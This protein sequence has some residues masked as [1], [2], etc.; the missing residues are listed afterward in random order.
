MFT[1]FR[2]GLGVWK[3][4][5]NVRYIVIKFVLLVAAGYMAAAYMAPVLY[6]RVKEISLSLNIGSNKVIIGL[7]LFHM[8]TFGIA[9]KEIVDRAYERN[10]DL[11]YQLAIS[12]RAGGICTMLQQINWYAYAMIVLF[13][14]C[15]DIIMPR[16]LLAL[17]YTLLYSIGF[18][19][20]YSM[21]DSGIYRKKRMDFRYFSDWNKNREDRRRAKNPTLEVFEITI[22]RLYQCRSLTVGKV[23]LLI[24][25]IYCSKVRMLYDSIFLLANLFLILLNDTYWKKESG[26]FQYFSEIGIPFLQYLCVHFAAG[27]CFNIVVPLLFFFSMGGELIS[28][29]VI[30]CFLSYLLIFWYM[31][32]AYLYLTV[33]RDKEGVILLC[34]IFFLVMALLPPVGLFIMVWLYKKSAYK[35]R[36]NECFR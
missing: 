21:A 24:F 25:I 36:G 30:F 23:L 33:K 29:V 7:A 28:T 13:V 18:S 15:D 2:I 6:E 9:A 10:K 20:Y 19:I 4:I 5:V 14:I 34:E 1:D 11:F 3:N 31:A 26:N 16:C 8:V 22:H 12:K 17:L 32:Q 35:W 27:I